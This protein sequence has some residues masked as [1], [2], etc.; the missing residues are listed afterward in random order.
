RM[1]TLHADPRYGHF[2]N[3]SHLPAAEKEL[4]YSWIQNGAPEGERRDP[5]PPIEFPKGWRIPK[6]DMVLTTR[7][8]EVP[9]SGEVQY[10]YFLVDP[11]FKEDKWVKAAEA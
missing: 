10:Q 8:F 6:P 3:D 4:I 1:P 11:G 9:A 5:P 7:R 2:S